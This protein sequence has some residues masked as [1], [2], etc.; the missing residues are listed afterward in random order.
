[1]KRSAGIFLHPTSLPSPYGIGDLGAAAYEWVMMLKKCNQTYWQVC[2]LGPTGF[3]D[4]PY[5]CLSSF[6]GNTQLISPVKL[7][8]DGLIA[9]SDISGY[10]SLPEERVDFSAVAVEKERIFRKAYDRFA[11]S[12]DFTVF[13]EQEK[14]WLDSYALYRVI[15]VKSG[16]ASWNQWEAQFKLRYPAALQTMEKFEYKEIRYHKFLQFLFYRQW[17][18]LKT[19]AN[20]QG[21]YIIGDIPIY[22][23]GDSADTWALPDY[24]EFDER[25]NPTRVAGVPPDYFS[26]T[27]Q[28]WGNPIYKWNFMQVDRYAW[29]ISRIKKTLQLVD[30]IRLD[31]FRGFESFWAVPADRPDA[32]QGEW[33]A[34]PGIDFFNQVRQSLGVLP[35]IAEDLGNITPQVIGLR[36][37]AGI[38]GMKVLQFAFD[39]DPTNWHLPYNI[40]VDNI[41]YTGTHDNDTTL[42]WFSALPDKEKKIVLDFLDCRESDVV[43]Q[44][45]RMAYAS[46]GCLCIIPLQDVF[47]LDA[48]HR[49][50]TPGTREGNWQW[51]FTIEMLSEGIE[52]FQR[53]GDRARIYGRCPPPGV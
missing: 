46:P 15:K 23:A 1:M 17:N 48:R 36:L 50:N 40:V 35:L 13:C 51:R 5:Q 29:W 8:E 28:L 14:Y 2:P 9:R 24:F 16:N 18:Q 47:E 43:E 26:A 45:V 53:L 20:S 25:C 21:I 49:M 52:K 4:S 31:H 27:G 32:V 6:A 22:V 10:A 12:E 42:G 33:V 11:D 19:F 41:V 3:G 44:L 7:M 34:G 38:P 30:V 39:G 37:A